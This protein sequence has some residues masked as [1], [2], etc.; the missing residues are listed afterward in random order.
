MTAVEFVEPRTNEQPHLVEA[1]VELHLKWFGEYDYAIPELRDNGEL[2][3]QREDRVV[4]Q[5]LVLV[6]GEPAGYAI[7]HTNI[8]RQIGVTHFLAI[9]EDARH[10]R[11]NNLPLARA[12]MDHATSLVYDDAKRLNLTDFHGMA[13]EAEAELVHV[14]LRWG[15]TVLPVNYHEPYY[16]VR[17]P[18]HG[19][20]TFF[21]RTLV[22]HAAPGHLLDAAASGRAAAAAFLLDHYRLPPD[23]PEVAW[24]AN[25]GT[26]R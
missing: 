19:E 14:W 18:E 10:L 25:D 6:D 5:I 12:L 21:D 23:H 9:N 24:L 20:P 26:S 2:P 15:Y 22:G 4:H 1:V 11:V 7:V 3:P 16:G 17:W 13:A 8:T